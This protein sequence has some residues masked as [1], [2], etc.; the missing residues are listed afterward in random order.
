MKVCLRSDYSSQLDD[1][2]RC[3]SGTL[4]AAG[5]K[6]D[7][8]EGPPGHTDP[9][10]RD[11]SRSLEHTPGPV[12]EGQVERKPHERR[13]DARARRQDQGLAGRE[14]VPAEKPL[15][16]RAGVEGRD[17]RGRHGLAGAEV[18]Q[19]EPSLRLADEWREAVGHSGSRPR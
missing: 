2:P 19:S 8:G 13:V 17:D 16:P 5:G 14:A 11:A 7:D 4:Q 10:R 6:L 1:I 9:P 3:G 12:E 15:P 18:P